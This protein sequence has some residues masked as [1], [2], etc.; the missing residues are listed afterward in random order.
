MLPRQRPYTF[1]EHQKMRIFTNPVPQYLGK[2]RRLGEFHAQVKF[3]ERPHPLHPTPTRP[4]QPLPPGVHIDEKLA[5][6]ETGFYSVAIKYLPRSDAV[7]VTNLQVNADKARYLESLKPEH[8]RQPIVVV[9][10]EQIYPHI[11]L[12][13]GPLVHPTPT[14][15][16]R[17]IPPP[18]R[19]L[20]QHDIVNSIHH[21]AGVPDKDKKNVKV[22]IEDR[23]EGQV[24]TVKR[25]EEEE[26][27][28]QV[29]ESEF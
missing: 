23:A 14:L 29:L 7:G 18:L 4:Y 17:L 26:F 12:P 11:P 13:L 19:S 21:R 5:F 6:Y 22:A 10:E 1:E 3:G 16:P 25:E 8:Q 15:A 2:I 28:L 24:V 27:V 20:T 9:K